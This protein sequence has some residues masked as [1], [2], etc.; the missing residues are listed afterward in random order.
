MTEYSGFDSRWSNKFI[1]PFHRAQTAAGIRSSNLLWSGTE[2]CVPRGKT[3]HAC[4][5]QRTAMYFSHCTYVLRVDPRSWYRLATARLLSYWSLYWQLYLF[6]IYRIC[7]G[8][9][10]LLLLLLAPPPPPL[11]PPPPPLLPPLLLLLP[12]LLQ[13]P[14]L[15]P[16]PQPLLLLP[17]PQPLLLLLQQLLLLLLLLLLIL[18]IVFHYCCLFLIVMICLFLLLLLLLAFYNYSLFT[19]A[20]T[21]TITTTTTVIYYHIKSLFNF[22]AAT[23]PYLS[24]LQKSPKLFLHLQLWRQKWQSS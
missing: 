8:H 4:S 22:A 9:I 6:F 24:R 19:V 2:G 12:P 1:L 7:I 18:L 11:L 21:T 23:A 5:W 14:L 20:A 3:S 16:P 15:L 17:P 10:K 13:L